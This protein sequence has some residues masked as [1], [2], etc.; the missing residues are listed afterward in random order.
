MGVQEDI[1]LLERQI[2]ELKVKYEQYFAGIEKREP[3]KDREAVAKLIRQYSGVTL[4]NTGQAFRLNQVTASFSALNAY[5]TR[6]C[7]QI[8]DGTY[9]RDKFKLKLKERDA[10]TGRSREGA[11]GAEGPARFREG[12]DPGGRELQTLYAQ[13]IA[14][15][16]QAGETVAGLKPETLAALIKQQVPQITRKFGCAAVEFRV[17]VE[18]GKAKLKA[19]PK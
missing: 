3:I 18:G 9:Q 13:L 7:Q 5:W 10:P 2:R 15:K 1:A 4:T 14:A 16:K 17:V 8:E 12:T 6:I 11:N 19:T